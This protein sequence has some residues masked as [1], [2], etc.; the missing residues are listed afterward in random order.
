MP[1]ELVREQRGQRYATDEDRMAVAI[2]LARENVERRTGG[3]FGAAIFEQGS[4][5]L[6]A[7]GVNSVVRLHNST[8]H[9][10]IVAFMRAQAA[11]ASF[12]LAPPGGPT[13]ELFT[14]CEPCAMCLGAVLWSGVKRVIF[15]AHRTD[16]TRLAFDEGPVFPESLEYLR[17]RGIQIEGGPLRDAARA[18]MEAYRQSG[19]PIYNA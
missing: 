19:A 10:E 1:D 9:A 2:D 15:A 13:H 11:L 4:G 17:K 16:A 18:V 14:S 3:P 6:V 5:R 8:L 7:I 12:T